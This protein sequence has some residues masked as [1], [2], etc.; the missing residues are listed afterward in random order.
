MSKPDPRLFAHK[1]LGRILSGAVTLD[2]AL[3][4]TGDTGGIRDARDR[5]FLRQLVITTLRRKGHLDDVLRR[6][7]KRPMPPRAEAAKLWI[8]L[9]LAQ[10]LFLDVADHAAVD[11]SVG[12]IAAMRHPQDQALKG[13]ANA[14]L[15]RATQ[16]R[17]ALTVWLAGRPDTN[18]PK[19]LRHRWRDHY[20][21]DVTRAIAAA[22]LT[23]PPLDLSHKPERAPE[24]DVL[25][26]GSVRLTAA[27]GRIEELPGFADGNWW[28]QDLAASLPVRLLGDVSSKRVLDLC[29]APGGKTL[30][31]AA[32][33]ANVTA[34]DRSKPRL[35]RLKENL[36]R[37]GLPA[38]I[39]TSDALE[40]ADRD[41]FDAILLDAPC[42]ATGTLRRH[43][44]IAW[45]RSGKDVAKL[46]DLQARLFRHAFTLLRPG[47]TLVYC[48]CSLEAEEGEAQAQAFLADESAAE[49]VAITA[50][51]IGELSDRI[52][53]DGDLRTLPSHFAEKGGMD[54]FFAVRVQ[55][56]A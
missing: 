26:P 13:L 45:T 16:E 18:L 2:V 6:L 36:A 8:Q 47:G 44:D 49:R 3:A 37:T 14:V 11:T 42:S 40:F 50:S 38:K 15:R 5:A 23:Q 52:T 48:T 27:T 33:G 30:Q 20:G 21:D 55:R 24:G 53:L 28:V 35:G 43:P 22:Q 46:A 32:A 19:W 10:I 31:L 4:D 25:V 17:D 51:E 41:G 1:A 56:K 12:A 9:G 39:V 54:G 29:A 34:L 7:V